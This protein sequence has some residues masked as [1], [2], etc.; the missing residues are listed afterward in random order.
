M[1][2]TGEEDARGISVPAATSRPAAAGAAP[3]AAEAR[4]PAAEGS[5]AS[6]AA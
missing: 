4:G 6:A 5:A 3:A 1:W 2:V